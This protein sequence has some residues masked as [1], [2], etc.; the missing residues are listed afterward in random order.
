MKK[1]LI[2]IAMLLCALMFSISG[3]IANDRIKSSIDSTCCKDCKAD[4]CQDLCK[5]WNS[6]SRDAQ[7]SDA[8]KKVKEECKEICKESNGCSSNGKSTCTPI[9]VKGCCK[10]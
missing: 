4:K 9:D 3:V 6:M 8:G 5:Q 7:K 2:F 10:K 1:L